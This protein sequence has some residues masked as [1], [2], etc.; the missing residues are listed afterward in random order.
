MSKWKEIA[1]MALCV[2]LAFAMLVVLI[3][4]VG[5]MYGDTYVDGVL[6][7]DRTVAEMVNR[8]LV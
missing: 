3:F 2:L 4:M 7:F 6:G 8:G 5:E 1:L